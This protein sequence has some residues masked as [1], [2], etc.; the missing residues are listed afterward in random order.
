MGGLRGYLLLLQSTVINNLGMNVYSIMVAIWVAQEVGSASLAGAL[1]LVGGTSYAF[2]AL[3]GGVTADR[4]SK[5]YI[6]IFGMGAISLTLLG[7]SVAFLLTNTLSILVVSVFIALLLIGMTAGWSGPAYTSILPS[8]L[9]AKLL[10][11]INALTAIVVPLC[12]AL[13]KAIGGTL[14]SVWSLSVVAL[15]ASL[16]CLL[17]MLTV[18]LIRE[19][20]KS[21]VTPIAAN[22]KRGV[23]RGKL[24]IQELMEGLMY[25]FNHKGLRDILCIAFVIQSYLGINFVTQLFS[26]ESVYNVE[27][28]RYG[29][30]MAI[31]SIGFLLGSFVAGKQFHRVSGVLNRINLLQLIFIA[32][33]FVC[34]SLVL[35]D[36]IELAIA[37]MTVLNVLAAILG[38]F[39]VTQIQLMI[40]SELRTRVLSVYQSGSF[41]ASSSGLLAGVLIDFLNGNTV[42]VQAIF[43]V[44]ACLIVFSLI[45]VGEWRIFMTKSINVEKSLQE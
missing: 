8:L 20:A 6:I 32:F 24:F 13:G 26:V 15:T 1:P 41:F 38:L 36:T 22:S 27:T 29:H 4:Y 19:P 35:A 14:S 37:A 12:S 39:T 16:M 23:R 21:E 34:V 33:P 45:R 11:R 40:P 3:L 9:S 42:W 17:S 5:K 43:G 31:S 18:T 44:L 2:S 25:A 10:P 7:V 28:Y 30:L